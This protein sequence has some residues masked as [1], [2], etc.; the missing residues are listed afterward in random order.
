MKTDQ[1]SPE[2][3]FD[4]SNASEYLTSVIK[5]KIVLSHFISGNIVKTY[6]DLR[7]QYK[8]GEITE[9]QLVSRILALKQ[10]SENPEN[11]NA[12]NV[13][14]SMD[15]SPEYISR[16]EDRLKKSDEKSAEYDSIIE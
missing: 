3:M 4:I 8:A 5:A 16:F 14:D 11:I 9:E 6:K 13:D 1:L 10:K 12:E 2:Q 15:F 7:N